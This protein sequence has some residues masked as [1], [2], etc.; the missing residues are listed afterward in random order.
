M[1]WGGGRTRIRCLSIDIGVW[2]RTMLDAL[3][4]QSSKL[5]MQGTRI[6]CTQIGIIVLLSFEMAHY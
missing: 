6:Q 3:G 5:S 2:G 1:L 4:V